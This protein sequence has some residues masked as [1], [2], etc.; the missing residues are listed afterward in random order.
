M[1]LKIKRILCFSLA[2]LTLAS[3]IPTAKVNAAFTQTNGGTTTFDKF[4]VRNKTS[5]TQEV[6]FTF[7]LTPGD[8]VSAT[9]T[10]PQVFA[11]PSGGKLTYN[12]DADDGVVNVTFNNADTAHESVQ[13]GDKINLPDYA[14]YSK[15]S[16]TVDLTGVTF[17]APGVYRWKITET[18]SNTGI[19]NDTLPVRYLDVYVTQNS[20]QLE[21]GTNAYV[22]HKEAD[23]IAYGGSKPGD[24]NADPDPND[25]GTMTDTKGGYVS[26]CNTLTQAAG[27]FTVNTTTTGNM[28]DV[29]KEFEYV[30]EVVANAEI[31]KD[32][33]FKAEWTGDGTPEYTY[34]DTNLTAV[35]DKY[36]TCVIKVKLKSGQSGK[37]NDVNSGYVIKSGLYLSNALSPTQSDY[38]IM[39]GYK[40]S[41]VLDVNGS[42]NWAGENTLINTDVTGTSHVMNYTVTKNIDIPTGVNID[43]IPWIVMIGIAGLLYTSKRFNKNDIQ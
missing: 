17:T 35:A 16:V 32:G 6:Q 9:S 18:G 21:V 26:F 15:K 41:Y 22:M 19:T 27:T 14:K 5:N 13:G 12:G 33:V 38:I 34:K 43:L 3:T 42:Q 23:V 30:F 7:T 10:T 37:I 1:H 20:G 28:A 29:D 4:Y 24:E 2:A 40:A 8:Q 36:D 31:F 25:D 11:G 39:D